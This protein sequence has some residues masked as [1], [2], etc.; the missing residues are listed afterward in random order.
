MS[1]A[2]N[3]AV[4]AAL[5]KRQRQHCVWIVSLAP[6]HK[7]RA[8]VWTG[9][10]Y[11]FS[12][13][14]YDPTEKRTQIIIRLGSRIL[15]PLYHFTCLISP[16]MKRLWHSY[17]HKFSWTRCVANLHKTCTLWPCCNTSIAT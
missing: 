6:T 5:V 15:N 8:Q 9:H 7:S 12:S 1:R 14:R 2:V 3:F 10:T 4:N 17:K 11:R 16:E 13:L